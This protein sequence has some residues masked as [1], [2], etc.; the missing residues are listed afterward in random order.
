METLGEH[1]DRADRP[2][3]REPVSVRAGVGHARGRGARGDREHRHRR[4]HADPSRGEE[5]RVLGRGGHAGELRRGA[6][7]SCEESDGQ[8]SLQTRRSLALEAF[9][10]TARYDAAIARWFAEREDDFPSQYTRSFEKVLDLTYGENPHQRAAYYA[11]TARAHAPDVDGVEAARQGAVVQQPARPRLGPAADRGVRA[12]GGGD[13]QAQQPVRRGGWR[14]ARGGVRQARS[15]PIRR[16]R[17]AASS[18]STGRST[19]ALAEKLNAMFVEAVFAPGYDED[20]LDGPRAEAERAA[21]REPGAARRSRS[22]ST[23][24][25]ACAA[26]SS[27]RTATR[28]WR[29][30]R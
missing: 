23:T 24:S 28:G 7:A 17:S 30:A 9:A 3:V 20:A 25:S 1:D 26:G 11:E 2:R 19:G 8:L 16:A 27:C 18:A 5:P 21:A 22:R 4:S 29:S 6:R 10:Y 13:H 15:R 12:A 14:D